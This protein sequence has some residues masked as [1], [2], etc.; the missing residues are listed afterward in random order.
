MKLSSSSA[1]RKARS[2]AS[3]FQ[4][5]PAPRPTLAEWCRQ[6]CALNGLLPFWR[7]CHWQGERSARR[8]CPTPRAI[9]NGS[10]RWCK[11]RANSDG[12]SITRRSSI[13]CSVRL[14]FFCLGRSTPVGGCEVSKV[15]S[16]PV[17]ESAP[18]A[19]SMPCGSFRGLLERALERG[20]FFLFSDS[21]R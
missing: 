20:N 8:G 1:C 4:A 17:Q 13:I 10:R 14:L 19:R 3:G 7:G 16:P 6:P 12:K 18:R 11:R 5:A 2:Q 9:L 15:S 21:G